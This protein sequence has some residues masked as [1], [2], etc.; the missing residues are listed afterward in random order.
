MIIE[1]VP[2][3]ATDKSEGK[4]KPYDGRDQTVLASALCISGKGNYPLSTWCGG[5]ARGGSQR[6]LFSAERFLEMVSVGFKGSLGAVKRD[7]AAQAGTRR[8]ATTPSRCT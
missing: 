6:R 1:H 5:T 3:D 4:S 2:A 8:Y 7:K